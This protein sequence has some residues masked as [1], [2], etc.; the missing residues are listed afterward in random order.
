M[1]ELIERNIKIVIRTAFH[2]S[3][4]LEER[5]NMLSKDM[6]DILKRPKIGLLKLKIIM[7]EI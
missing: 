7:S 2:I 4:K 3:E 6:K 5:L 1:I